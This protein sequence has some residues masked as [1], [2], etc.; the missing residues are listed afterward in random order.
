MVEVKVYVEG[1]GEADR[2]LRTCREGFTKFFRNAGL[3]GIMPRVVA[4]GSRGQAMDRFRS[5][6]QL[7]DRDSISVLLVDS[8]DAVRGIC[9]GATAIPH[10][11]ARD[12][13]NLQPVASNE[14]CHLMTQVM[15]TWFHAD[16]ATLA[17]FFGQ[18]FNPGSL[19][20]NNL[21][22][23]TKRDIMDALHNA[24]RSSRKGAYGK[25]AHSFELLAKIDAEKVR[26]LCPW[27]DRLVTTVKELKQGLQPS[28]A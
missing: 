28:K 22:S 27:A 17:V 25:G 21:E 13:K 1:G 26:A 4:C 18:G 14:K 23:R 9:S 5:A 16:P 6:V 8:E 11:D 19:Y 20:N 15:E 7:D 3:D 2:I 10:L 12:G 24:T